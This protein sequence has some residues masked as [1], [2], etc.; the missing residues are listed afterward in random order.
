MKTKVNVFY[1]D[2]RVLVFN[3]SKTCKKTEP[4][5][6]I[7]AILVPAALMPDGAWVSRKRAVFGSLAFLDLECK[8][9]Q[10]GCATANEEGSPKMIGSKRLPGR[11]GACSGLCCS[12]NASCSRRLPAASP[13]G[14]ATPGLAALASN[15]GGATPRSPPAWLVLAEPPVPAAAC[16]VGGRHCAAGHAAVLC[17]ATLESEIQTPMC[18]AV[19]VKSCKTQR[20]ANC[21]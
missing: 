1:L 19:A 3:L 13:A 18:Q 9:T 14:G 7:V 16:M 8:L 17:C 21:E 5:A 15:V 11:T 12:R 10:A 2:D 6:P 4:S 20:N